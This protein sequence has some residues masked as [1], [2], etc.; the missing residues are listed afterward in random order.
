M[1]KT[2]FTGPIRSGSI[3]STSGTTLGKD[4]KNIGSPILS[5]SYPITQAGS[6]AALATNIVIPANSRITSMQ[7]YVDAVWSGAAATFSIGTSVAATEL[8]AAAGGDASSLNI[9]NITSGNSATRIGVWGNVGTTDV[10]IWF[11]STNTGT[12]TGT[13]TVN[14]VQD[15]EAA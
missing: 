11:L 9:R 3:I 8:T 1:S 13:L 2:T 7:I 15:Q 6:A 14:Y 10:R 4:V 12:G 5:Q